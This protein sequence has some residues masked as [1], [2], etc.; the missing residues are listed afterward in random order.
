[1]Q[2]KKKTVFVIAIFL[3]FQLAQTSAQE[4]QIF[5]SVISKLA[6]YTNKH[7][8]EKTY[9]HT[10]KEFYT[11]GETI[12]FKVYLVD[13]IAHTP[14]KKSKVI[15]VDLLNLQDSIVAQRK[16]Y[17]DYGFGTHGDIEIP[18]TT[19]QG[20]YKL[21]SYT[22]YMLNEKEP[23][24]FSKE[25]HIW[26]QQTNDDEPF[27]TVDTLAQESIS[28]IKHQR[29][30]IQF[31][32]EGG[33]LV[34]G[35]LNKLGIKVTNTQGIGISLEGSI[36][37]QDN[38][39]VS[40]FKTFDHG[41]GTALYK[42]EPGKSYYASILIN[43]NEEKYA[44]PLPLKK[45]YV[46]NANNNGESVTLRV[47][48]N[49]KSGLLG[50]L[51]VGHMRGYTFFK[52][53]EKSND[54]KYSVRLFTKDLGNG[55]A[56]FTLFTAEGEPVCERLIFVDG[57]NGKAVLST[58]TDAKKYE[59]RDKVSVEIA[60]NDLK[61]SP[62]S[63]SLS[64]S[65]IKKPNRTKKNSNIISWLLLNSDIGMTSF[66]PDLFLEDNS[67]SKN[68]LLD[69]L[70][71]THGWRRFIWKDF[72]NS[73]VNKQ[74]AFE[75]EKG[76]MIRGQTTSFRNKYSPKTS[77]VTLSTLD[78]FVYQEKKPTNFQGNF[79]FGPFAF[80]DTIQ[81]FVKAVPV[82][83]SKKIRDNELAIHADDFLLKVPIENQKPL[84]H[85]TIRF[86]F[87]KAYKELAYNR[88]LNDFK[89]NPKVTQ[90]KEVT[91]KAKKKTR[92]EIIDEQIN[93]I[94]IYGT[95]D[96][97]VFADSI[98]GSAALGVFDLLRNIAGVQVF[99]SYP[100]QTIQIRGAASFSSSP[101][102]LFL[103]D[104]IEVDVGFVGAMLAIE[105]ELIDVLKGPSAA[106]YGSRAANGVIAIYS[107]GTIW[108][109]DYK[110]QPSP[111]IATFK[112]DGFY[113]VRE[114]YSPNYDVPKPKHEQGDYRTTLHWQ[115]NIN[116][117][118]NGKSNF[119]FFTNDVPGEYLIKVEGITLDGRPV[120]TVQ[121]FE[122]D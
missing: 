22:K 41:L 107:K 98:M 88:E 106:I 38:N 83:E 61:N 113:K 23:F 15:Y 91:V 80:Q 36:V 64:S 18:E 33:N 40:P 63:G 34:N 73:K 97:R 115:P 59:K 17:V 57:E 56:H 70:M 2:M 105:V 89:Y 110:R 47:V 53:I 52:R 49:H 111:G 75:P 43:G 27:V 14:S 78:P 76:I 11:N 122:V 39:M 35:I 77:W 117:D 26:A 20:T 3:L 65:I 51:L 32:P 44:M 24:F 118:T 13:G 100:D 46:L 101:S 16:L 37:D 50:T 25:I 74:L 67:Y 121:H 48:T 19:N 96:N 84:V 9:I 114:F 112:V 71:L 7:S 4:N 55:V 81:A 54:T 108:M 120:S 104:G 8:P 30:N 21:R 66:D 28:N 95:P 87:P 86:D 72:L 103:L 90:L 109:D 10:D 82:S 116:V 60:L 92:E 42:P 1:M 12:W 6:S 119:S 69:M 93:K 58:K 68:H 85:E 94:A 62:L 99:G 102:P 45:G 79:S 29:P 31:F 5:Q